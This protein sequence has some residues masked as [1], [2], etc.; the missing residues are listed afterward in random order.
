[1][2]IEYVDSESGAKV[3]RC[4]KVQLILKW[5]G[6]L[7]KLGEK[8]AI[9]LGRKLRHGELKSDFFSVLFDLKE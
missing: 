9:N 1:M 5:G 8:Q 3:I 2:S 4:I 7:T 6:N